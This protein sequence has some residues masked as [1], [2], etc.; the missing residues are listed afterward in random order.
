MSPFRHISSKT[1]T[2]PQKLMSRFLIPKMRFARM[3]VGT[4]VH[5]EMDERARQL[6]RANDGVRSDGDRQEG[7]C[8]AASPDRCR[9]IRFRNRLTRRDQKRPRNCR[10]A[11]GSAQAGAQGDGESSAAKERPAGAADRAERIAKRDPEPERP[12]PIA[13]GCIK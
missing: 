7:G 1:S 12:F 10:T 6:D 13:N 5:H 4:E 2:C 3:L 11:Q 8:R 9:K